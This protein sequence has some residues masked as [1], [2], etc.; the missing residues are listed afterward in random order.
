MTIPV[1]ISGVGYDHS[2]AL[3]LEQR[4][5][6]QYL[7]FA[8]PR[9]IDDLSQVMRY[10]WPAGAGNNPTNDK[11]PGLNLRVATDFPTFIQTSLD[12]Q[13]RPSYGVYLRDDNGDLHSLSDGTSSSTNRIVVT[14]SNSSS[15]PTAIQLG[16]AATVSSTTGPSTT[17]RPG[18]IVKPGTTPPIIVGRVQFEAESGL[19]LAAINTRIAEINSVIETLAK[20]LSVQGDLFNAASGLVR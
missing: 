2:E 11:G 13:G 5:I 17:I 1:A 20:V 16:A 9:D 18:D 4:R 6:A 8:S 12:P 7:S 15:L 10:N 14:P 19:A 3:A